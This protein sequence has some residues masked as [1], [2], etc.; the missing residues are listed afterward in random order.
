MELNNEIFHEKFFG[1]AYRKVGT[2]GN[3]FS[4]AEFL[5]TFSVLEKR[6]IP[7]F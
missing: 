1:S 4:G 6:K 7:E 3:A 2:G 5:V